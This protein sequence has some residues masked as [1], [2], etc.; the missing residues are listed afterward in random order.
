MYL[1]I[2]AIHPITK[3]TGVLASI[4]KSNNLGGE[5]LM[6]IKKNNDKKKFAVALKEGFANK[7]YRWMYFA[8]VIMASVAIV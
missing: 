3:V 1:N 4:I 8:L 6:A 5:I 2:G 7:Q